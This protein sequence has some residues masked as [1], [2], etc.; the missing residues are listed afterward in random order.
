M[1]DI[2]ST[3]DLHF[4]HMEDKK[5]GEDKSVY[6][7]LAKPITRPL[8]WNE[9]AKKVFVETDFLFRAHVLF[10]CVVGCR[11]CKSDTHPAY[12]CPFYE[13]PGWLAKKPKVSESD[14][15][16]EDKDSD[17]EEAL[18]MSLFQKVE[19][20]KKDQGKS[21]K[22]TKGDS[23]AGKAERKKDDNGGSHESHK[24]TTKKGNRYNPLT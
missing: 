6:Q 15:S 3:M 21:K 22:K 14:E 2:V 17:T 11:W 1:M 5:T 12:Q 23:N 24:K 10:H 13:I 4:I 19:R 16:L 8:Y 18:D 20:K 9:L 7:I